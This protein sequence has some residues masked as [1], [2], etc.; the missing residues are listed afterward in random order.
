MNIHKLG[1]SSSP[2]RVYVNINIPFRP[3][4]NGL[5]PAIFSAEYNDL[6]LKDSSDYYLSVQSFLIPGSSLPIFIAQVNPYPNLNIN[7]L[8]YAV[9]LG[10]NGVYHTTNLQYLYNN[11]YFGLPF[12][13]S[14]SQIFG[15]NTNPYYYVYEY[16]NMIDYIN[17]ALLQS[18][19]AFT[20]LPLGSVAP[21]FIYNKTTRMIS[22]IAQIAYYDTNDPIHVPLPITVYGNTPLLRFTDGMIISY[23]GF[24]LP[25]HMDFQ[26]K[27]QNQFNNF[28][29]P[30]YLA[31]TIPPLYYQMEQN[32]PAMELWND[33]QSIALQSN[34]LNITNAEF[35][36]SSTNNTNQNSQQIV[37]YQKIIS[38]FLVTADNDAIR[39]PI[40][41]TLQ[42]P[43][44][45]YNMGNGP[46][47]KIDIQ[48]YWIN[49]VNVFNLLYVPE[50]FSVK[51][52]L[53]FIKKSSY[54]E[55][56]E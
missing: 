34:L 43:Y 56:T 29:N 23:L 4:S 28:Y 11:P 30:P 55:Y 21:Y 19:N 46:V 31:P 26:Y 33:V 15:D 37:N 6:I 8:I 20:G 49:N 17:F 36:P 32:Y 47:R 45:L 53:V 48:I 42:S 25:N 7:Q 39:G 44:R 9:T 40:V 18:F 1:D 16:Q 50:N 51:I 2:D 12:P 13:P 38:D 54:H 14:E 24:D 52:K 3:N 5:S 35:Y 22:L 41:Y 27:I 10:Y